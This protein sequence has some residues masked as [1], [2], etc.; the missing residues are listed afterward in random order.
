MGIR[1]K[2]TPGFLLTEKQGRQWTGSHCLLPSSSRRGKSYSELP[3]MLSLG[4]LSQWP[5]NALTMA[6]EI[7]KPP[8]RHPYRPA[9]CRYS[10]PHPLYSSG[11]PRLGIKCSPKGWWQEARVVPQ[12]RS[13]SYSDV[14]DPQFTLLEALGGSEAG[15]GCL[16]WGLA[17]KS[18][19]PCA[20]VRNG[21]PCAPRL[22][23][24]DSPFP[25]VLPCICPWSLCDEE[26]R[27][28]GLELVD[29]SHSAPSR[30]RSR[31]G[32]AEQG[33][34]TKTDI[35]ARGWEKEGADGL[36]NA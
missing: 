2:V 16:L 25:F 12:I 31:V 29:S 30:E 13:L 5:A 19:G 22:H 4:L 36:S 8:L 35:L 6:G 33:W 7:P 24:E 20:A 27:G 9:L 26:R 34:C 14:L 32:W 11:K 10:H 23:S 28:Q 3:R 17:R 1:D 21:T 18:G 15:Q